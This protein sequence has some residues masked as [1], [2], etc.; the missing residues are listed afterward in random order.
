MYY[1]K[2][3]TIYKCRDCNKEVVLDRYGVLEHKDGSMKHGTFLSAT[4][5]RNESVTINA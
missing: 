4:Y 3:I 1:K 2:N 5:L